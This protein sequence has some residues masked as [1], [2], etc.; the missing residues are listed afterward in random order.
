MAE[1]RN[2]I[3]GEGKEDPSQLLA[4]P[5]NY[6]RHPK[7]Q[8][9]ALEGVLE[10]VGW[11]QQVVVNTTTGHMVDGHARVE[12]AIRRE[13][14]TVPVLYVT[15]SEREEKIVLATLDPI[16]GMAWHDEEAVKLLL[17]GLEAENRAV[18]EFMQTLVVQTGGGKAADQD[19]ARASLADTLLAPPF[20]ILDARQGYWQDRKRAWVALGIK[21]ELGRGQ[22]GDK[23]AGGGLTF[24]TSAQP[25]H[26]HDRKR[27]IETRDGREY[28]WAE[29]SELYP[30]EIKLAGDSIF[31]PVL[32][33]IAYLWFAPPG[34]SVL[35]P[36]AGG[37]VRGIVAEMTGHPYTG[38]DLRPEQI[39]ANRANWE[40]I[41]QGGGIRKPAGTADNIIDQTPIEERGEYFLKR[42]DLWA[43]AGVRGG[44]ARS[45]WH[46]AQ[47]APGLVTAGSR[48][49]PQVNLVAQIA[50]RLGI[51]CRVHVP[52][53]DLTAEL[54]AAQR[55][56]AEVVQ[57]K[58]GHNSV[59]VARAREDAKERGWREIP[60][61][62]ECEEAIRQTAAQVA[63]L[64]WGQ[65]SRIVIPVG[66]GM[67]LAGLLHGLREHQQAGEVEVIGV[68]VGADPRKRLDKWAP[69]GWKDIVTLVKSP[70]DYHD[71]AKETTLDGVQLDPVYEAKCL[72]FLEPGDLL[73][74]VGIRQ[75]AVTTAAHTGEPNWIT[76]DSRQM[77]EFISESDFDLIFSCPPYADLEV[78]SDREEDISGMD[79]PDFIDAYRDIIAKACARLRDNRFAV[80]VV[81]DV[82]DKGGFYRNFIGDT[83]QAFED[84]GLRLY[85]EA[86]YITPT[87]SL[88]MR[89][90]NMFRASRKLGKGHQ[91]ML[92]FAKGE[93]EGGP[94]ESMTQ[95]LA[96]Q[97]EAERK[98]L[99]AY[100]K[101]LVF[102]K[103]DPKQATQELGA[104]PVADTE[105]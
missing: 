62:M 88:A 95:A 10:E 52:S 29:F 90:M 74:C 43:V 78:Y 37:S 24:T 3:T 59:I 23:T 40:E 25:G 17:D 30:E 32:A 27:E 68:Q 41:E 91:N 103:G 42:D 70:L 85:N 49:S 94:M 8:L 45:C 56:G 51:P 13:E 6:R 34:G 77:G 84:A 26:V 87:G 19:Q 66:S 18:A 81:G 69:K 58:P 44:K 2:R 20:S 50:A 1:L 31:D 75:S 4:N 53:G 48:E 98:L 22:D 76:G 82:R 102:A 79:Y 28:T 46:L 21:S 100:S 83:I 5:W 93:P 55:A 36:F 101:V 33:E 99:D 9:D 73:W 11:V 96:Q 67:N 61:G 16:A 71:H 14:K 97:F 105:L 60:F 92:V 65:F 38:I 39:D 12:L 54:R 57:H 72:P 64:P 35:D 7:A 86:I 15:L 104:V 47:G 80:F 63:N 89:A